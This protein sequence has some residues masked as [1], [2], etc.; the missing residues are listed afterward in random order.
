MKARLFVDMSNVLT[1]MANQMPNSRIHWSELG[2]LAAEKAATFGKQL[3]GM[4][5]IQ[6]RIFA[7][8]P[9]V[10]A[11][12]TREA[13]NFMDWMVNLQDHD[14]ISV[15]I[16]PRV[17]QNEHRECPHCHKT[18]D[19]AY[20]RE[21]AVDMTMAMDIIKLAIEG[22]ADGK[23]E[24]AIIATQDWDFSPVVHLLQRWRIPVVNLGFARGGNKLAEACDA[25]VTVQ[26]LGPKAMRGG[27]TRR[28]A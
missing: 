12:T 11:P 9:P 6:T 1:E 18:W 2:H 5:C 7:S 22:D 17:S 27:C 20:Q 13:N 15:F 28:S 3:Q 10:D 26:E 23:L 21:R 24:A 25:M 16:L 14:G 4:T 8:R 19:Y